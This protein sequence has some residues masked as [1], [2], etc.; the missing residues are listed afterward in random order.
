MPSTAKG[1]RH[2]IRRKKRALKSAKAQRA[3]VNLFYFVA[4]TMLTL[5]IVLGITISPG[6]FM[7]L[8]GAVMSCGLTTAYV[9]EFGPYEE[10]RDAKDDL[11]EMIEDF[12]DWKLEQANATVQSY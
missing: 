1:F 8:I 4:L 6:F 12:D 9:V 2:E 3:L 10:V 11:E 5:A 7:L